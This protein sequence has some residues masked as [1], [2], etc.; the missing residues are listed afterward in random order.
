MVATASIQ[1]EAAPALAYPAAVRRSALL[2]SLFAAATVGCAALTPP[3]TSPAEGGAPWT[4]LTSRHYILRTNLPPDEA[5]EALAEFEG[6]YNLFVDVAFPT[7]ESRAA[8]I[9][10]VVFRRESDYRVLARK[11]SAAYCCGGSRT[12][13]RRSPAARPSSTPWPASVPG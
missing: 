7:D 5:R 8:R 4:E 9:G 1:L 12:G 2:V 3:L 6:V 11:G 10:L 13:W